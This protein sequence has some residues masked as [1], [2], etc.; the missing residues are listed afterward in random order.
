MLQQSNVNYTLI[1]DLQ[2]LYAK[3]TS[4]VKNGNQLSKD[5]PVNKGLWQGCCISPTVFKI[6]IHKA[7]TQWKKKCRGMGI[8]LDDNCIYTLQFSDDQIVLALDKDDL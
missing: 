1:K 2:N 5:F 6:Y 8:E 3:S 7:L 4:K